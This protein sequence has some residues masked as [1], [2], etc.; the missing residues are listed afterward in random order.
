MQIKMNFH[1]AAVCF[2]AKVRIIKKT[3][4]S[5]DDLLLWT[6]LRLYHFVGMLYNAIWSQKTP[7]PKAL[8]FWYTKWSFGK[9]YREKT[10]AQIHKYLLSTQFTMENQGI[11][12]QFK[13][14]RCSD[15]FWKM[16]LD[17]RRGYLYINDPI[18]V[19]FGVLI[20]LIPYLSHNC[21]SLNTQV[22][23]SPA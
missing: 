21:D 3:R 22:L 6:N 7:N 20:L 18:F 17:Y 15:C 9:R 19:S 14:W 23:K 12:F 16:F 1:V 13:I 10:V 5:R 11:W 8:N 2:L 4:K